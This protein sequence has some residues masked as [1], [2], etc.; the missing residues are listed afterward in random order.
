MAEV[1]GVDIGGTKTHLA[2]A[3]DDG[4]LVRESVVPTSSWRDTPANAAALR[5]V[6]VT[7]LGAAAVT[8][9]IA[10]GAHGCDST[11]QCLALEKA[12]QE[13][14]DGPVTVV[15]DAELMPP[16]MGIDAAIGIAVGTGSIAVARGEAGELITAGGWGWLLGDE[17]S[18]AGIVREATRAVL[19][20]LDRG[21]PADAL[22]H[23][24]LAAFDAAD[25]PELFV[26]VTDAASAE[27]W[28]RY[29]AEV[30][31]AADEGSAI[32]AHVIREA[33]E[34]LA[35]LVGRL[36]LRGIPADA[37]VAGG[38]VIENQQRLRDAFTTAVAREFPTMSIHVLD[39]PPVMGAI[40][41]ARRSSSLIT[42]VTS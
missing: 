12:L 37:V 10:V 22:G 24:L 23:R 42:E 11:A 17:G 14:V 32:A 30:F 36:R 7:Q 13:L 39:R 33:G 28:G 26:A 20:D 27:E 29:A 21:R 34:Q 2:V 16:A 31:T 19:A 35:M 4:A 41:L 1:V 5:R 25:G 6:I 38:A 8:R 18:S 15:N 3:A 9:P 40:A